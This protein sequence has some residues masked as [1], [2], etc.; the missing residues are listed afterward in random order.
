MSDVINEEIKNEA[1]AEQASKPQK[2]KLIKRIWNGIKKPF[3]F[4]WKKSGP[5]REFMGKGRAGGMIL[6]IIVASQLWSSGTYFTFLGK[7]PLILCVVITAV[8][9]VIF[10]E[11]LNLIIK[12]VFGG[13]KRC[14]SYF[15]T[16]LMAVG[17][18]N[19]ISDQFGAVPGMLIMT[20]LL[21]LSS[22]I[23]GRIVW[24]FIRTRRF[25]QVFA[26]AAGVLSVSYLILFAFFYHNDNFG[27]SRISFY[28]GI[29]QQESY[30]DGF[31]SYLENGPY[32]VGTLSYG[33]GEGEDLAAGTID[34]SVYDYIED[35][36]DP[37]SALTRA[38]SDYDF[39][40]TPVKGQIWYPEGQSNCP[41]FFIVHGNHDSTTPSY[42]GYDYLGEYLASNGYAVVSVDENIINELG[43]NNDLRAVLLLENMKFLLDQSSS[44]GSLISGLIDPEKIA[45]G[46]HSRG[47]EMVATAYLFNELDSYPED[48][49]IKF[50]YH[51]NITSIVAIAPVVDQYRP[52][53]RSVELSDVSYL[54]LHGSNDQDV[55][56]MCGEKQYNNIKFTGEAGDYM[57]KSEV[58]ILGANHGQFNSLWG[59]YDSPT[60]KG[61]L[62]T[63]NFIAGDEQKLIAKAYIRTFLDLTLLGDDTYLSLLKDVSQYTGDLPDT[64]YITNF[65]DSDRVTLCS[66]DR[67]TD[68]SDYGNG[69]SIDVTGTKCWTIEPYTRGDGGEGEDYV[70]SLSWEE[71]SSPAI[72]VDFDPIDI[73]DGYICFGIAD[74]REDTED[75]EEGLDYTVTLKDANGNEV[76]ITRPVFVWHSLAVQLW[77]QDVFFGSYEYKH[78]IQGVV[79]TPDMIGQADLDLAQITGMTIT[80]DGTAEGEIII[81][82]I[83]YSV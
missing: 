2:E 58:Y 26:Y 70:L 29:Y 3:K 6:E 47:G 78:Q 61:Y 42:L 71:D 79:I 27:E 74:M 19:T 31:S 34:L 69:T 48:G 40:K 67:T 25:K 10:A 81:D 68:I 30:T 73:S 75:L 22:D 54:L 57:I 12:I 80:T 76:S 41:V 56:I 46:G 11:L 32:S 33:P 65:E 36:E 45:I 72:I 1:V 53:S 8:I 5:A 17:S 39:A 13:G 60:G 43:T 50:D 20:F 77:K 63:Y 49:S 83:G 55:S 66:F 21:V 16:S 4:L 28:N 44:S 7:I 24:S 23:T 82:D 59:Q 15:F 52:V 35:A 18:M 9:W 62:N 38:V 64:V 51:F 14:K 37:L